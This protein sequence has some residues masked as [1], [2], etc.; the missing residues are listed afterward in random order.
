MDLDM[1][2]SFSR[3]V[4]LTLQTQMVLVLDQRV[5]MRASEASRTSAEAQEDGVLHRPEDTRPEGAPSN[6]RN[7][8]ELVPTTGT[9]IPTDAAPQLTG[10][11]TTPQFSDD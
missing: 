6:S 1:K 9:G 7:V 10:L 5:A 2:R 4:I 8:L 3:P 11:H